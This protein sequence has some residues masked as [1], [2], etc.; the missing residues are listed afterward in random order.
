MQIEILKGIVQYL[1]EANADIET[2]AEYEEDYPSIQLH[3]IQE[4][5]KDP[6]SE[7]IKKYS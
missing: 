6:I 7:D 3:G 2:G 5:I 1:R 4:A